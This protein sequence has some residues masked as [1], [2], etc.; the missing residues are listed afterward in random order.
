MKLWR[1]SRK[2]HTERGSRP[3]LFRYNG[4]LKRDK[5]HTLCLRH[6]SLHDTARVSK[7]SFER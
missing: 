3:V 2:R 1:L 5:T 6:R 7:P 4:V